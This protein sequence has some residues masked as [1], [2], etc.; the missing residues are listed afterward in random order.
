MIGM[1]CLFARSV[2]RGGMGNNRGGVDD[3]VGNGNRSCNRGEGSGSVVG[4]LGDIS[5]DGIRVVVHVL[6]STVGKGN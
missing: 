3:R 6:N 5:V 1:G 4:D 2:D